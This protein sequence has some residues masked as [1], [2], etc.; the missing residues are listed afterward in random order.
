MTAARISEPAHETNSAR[1]RAPDLCR[2]TILARRTQVDLAVP[3]DVSLALLIPGIVDMISTHANTGDVDP[4]VASAQDA[5]GPQEWVL[6]KVGQPPLS[7]TL[8]LSEHG[9]RDGDLLLLE[10]PAAAAPTPLFDDIMYN[11]AM[12]DADRYN[13]WTNTSARLLGSVLAAVATIVG[14]FALLWSGAGEEDVIGGVCALFA[15]LLLLIAGTVT[16]RIYFDAQ[17]AL[18]LAGCSLPTAF[19]AGVLFVPGETS[20]AH[21]LLGAT[22]VGAIAVLALR[23]GGVGLTLF[24]GVAVAAAFVAPAALVAL[25][26]DASLRTVGAVAAAAALIGLAFAPRV[27]MLLAK[28]PLPNVPAPGTSVDPAEDD[29]SDDQALPTFAALTAKTERARRYLSGLIGA[30][31]LVTIGGALLATDI[32]GVD[33][34][35]WQGT[36]LALVCAAVLMFRGRTY[37]SA[38]QASALIAGGA[39]ILVAL[40]IDAAVSVDAPLAI[41]GAAMALAVAAL[42]LGILAPVR[43]FSPPVRR[44]V[45]LLEYACVAAVLPLVCWVAGLFALLR[46]I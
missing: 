37:A 9:I 42:V 1:V 27:S 16:A 35:Y 21:V 36:A 13:R 39:T 44:S 31:S 4:P 41:F 19:A 34:I 40:L 17:S 3:A 23:V 22:L 20:S 2:L 32:A 29:P 10:S 25:T 6:A 7:S 38:E 24:T 33:D 43:T 11:V 26:T 8:S 14:C 46:G 15:S 45:E 28:L 18:V 5:D 30:T 12:V